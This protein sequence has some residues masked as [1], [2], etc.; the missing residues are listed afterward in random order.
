MSTLT[1]RTA[2]VVTLVVATVSLRLFAQGQAVVDP[3]ALEKKIDELLHA[4]GAD[5]AYNSGAI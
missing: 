3:A 4:H 2:F 1:I 5:Y